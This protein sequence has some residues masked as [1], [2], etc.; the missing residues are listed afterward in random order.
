MTA[1]E[2]LPRRDVGLVDLVKSDNLPW[3]SSGRLSFLIL[4]KLVAIVL[5]QTGITQEIKAET[6]LRSLSLLCPSRY[7]YRPV[8][9]AAEIPLSGVSCPL[10]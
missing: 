7:K 4:V 6:F 3:R 8:L 5:D 10:C 1:I 2:Q 9:A